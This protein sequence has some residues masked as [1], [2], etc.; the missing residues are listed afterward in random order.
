[1][2]AMFS[3]GVS[4]NE[5]LLVGGEVTRAGAAR[6][7]EWA[8]RLSLATAFLSAVGDRLGAIDPEKRKKHSGPNCRLAQPET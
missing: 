8:L 3:R 4:R 2:T 5:G 1:M 6:W 7:T